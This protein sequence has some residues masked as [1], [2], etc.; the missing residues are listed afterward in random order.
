MNNLTTRKIVLGILMALVLAF[1]VQGI[2]DALT[3]SRPVNSNDL[4][5]VGVGEFT[6]TFSVSLTGP[7]S[8]VN[9]YQQVPEANIAANETDIPYYYIDTGDNGYQSETKISNSAANYY[10]NE[11]VTIAVSR[12]TSIVGL[13]VTGNG[14]TPTT[15]HTL[16]EDPYGK[17]V[18]A[19]DT[20]VTVR[21]AT[22]NTGEVTI[23]IS[24]ATPDEDF[25]S[26]SSRGANLVF[27]TYVVHPIWQV[28]RRATLSL[29]GVTNGVGDGFF[30]GNDQPIYNGDRNHYGVTYTVSGSGAG[31]YVKEGSRPSSPTVTPTLP[32]SSG[33]Q[34]YLR[35]GGA[36]RTVTAKVNGTDGDA[37]FSAIYIYGNPTLD[38]VTDVTDNQTQTGNPGAV[39]AEPFTVTVKD[40]LG[41]GVRGVP[42]KFDVRDTGVTSGGTLIFDENDGP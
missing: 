7:T 29:R 22:A 24:D 11:A 27:T 5:T 19:L 34:V 16:R 14:I 35:M 4:Q 42:V 37:V 18:N 21:L 12:G 31:V 9:N 26:G 38:I 23:T 1:S 8:K 15:S 2:A 32:T 33:A 36:T 28:D 20:S 30:D 39:I 17:G 13:D 41:I 40:G 25:T 10:N 6:V 3:L